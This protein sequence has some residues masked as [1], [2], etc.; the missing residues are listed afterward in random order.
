M[1]R[2]EV[3]MVDYLSCVYR[4]SDL[5]DD[6]KVTCALEVEQTLH[7]G[8]SIDKG[9][10]IGNT[11]AMT[12]SEGGLTNSANQNITAV[13]NQWKYKLQIAAG[14]IP[15]SFETTDEHENLHQ[16]STKSIEE[17]TCINK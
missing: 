11:S 5:T 15:G 9:K 8:L 16:T 3:E 13:R 1:S 7:Y 17:V 14:M 10:T 6:Y 12:D 4:N 2:C